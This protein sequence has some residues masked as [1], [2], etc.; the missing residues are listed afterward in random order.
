MLD[1]DRANGT[2][3][4]NPHRGGRGE[5]RGYEGR[6]GYVSNRRKIQQ[7]VQENYELRSNGVPGQVDTQ[8]STISQV[9]ATVG[10]VMGGRADQV[11]QQTGGRGGGEAG[12]NLEQ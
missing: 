12:A 4:P 3:T 5:G 11:R 8:R 1:N 7:L 6:G 2:V 10:S 9:T